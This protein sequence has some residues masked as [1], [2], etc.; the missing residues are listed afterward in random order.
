MARVARLQLALAAALLAAAA[1]AAP[2]SLL[3]APSDAAAAADCNKDE[4]VYDQRQNGSE[5]YRVHV[6]GVVV[7]VVP[8][9]VLV[10]LVVGAS[11]NSDLEHQLEELLASAGAGSGGSGSASGKPQPPAEGGHSK[12]PAKP[13][14]PPPTPQSTTSEDSKLPQGGEKPNKGKLRLS[15]LLLPLLRRL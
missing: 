5:N 10:P 1:L 13:T 11:S 3:D 8:A 2:S 12:P 6:D 9:E 7:A 14:P 15:H 4:T